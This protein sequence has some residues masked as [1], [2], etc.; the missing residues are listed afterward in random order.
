VFVNGSDVLKSFR[1]MVHPPVCKSAFLL[2]L[3][4]SSA[5]IFVTAQE[6]MSQLPSWSGV[7]VNANCTPDEAFAEAAKCTDSRA[8]AKLALYDDTTRQV[9]NLQPQNQAVGN[10]GNAV[11]VEGV[12]NG[13][14]I[15]VT[16]LKLLTGIGLSIGQ[17]APDFSTTDQFGKQQTLHTLKGSKG[18]ILL[19]FR[20][21]DW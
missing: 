21:A 7:I 12:L 20:S 9:F 13:D 8:N 2:V 10:L 14:T 4:L 6:H 17:K 15:Q 3:A 1:N 5:A 16:A 11:T 19:F 18:T